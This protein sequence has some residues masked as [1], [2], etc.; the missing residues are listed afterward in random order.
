MGIMENMNVNGSI[1]VPNATSAGDMPV[2]S[3]YAT[4]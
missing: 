1:A 4:L 3:Q 2:S